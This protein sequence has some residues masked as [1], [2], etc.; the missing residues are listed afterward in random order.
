MADIDVRGEQV[1]VLGGGDTGADC[2]G[3]AHRQGAAS[4]LNLHY[5]PAP[6]DVRDPSSPWPFTPVLLRVS[7]SHEEGGDRGWSVLAQALVGEDRVRAL[8]C[9]DVTWD[10]G[11]QLVE[12]SERD[13]PADRVLVA[14]GYAGV[15]ASWLDELGVTCARGTIDTDGDGLAAQGVF[16]CGDATLGASLVVDAIQEG[17]AVAASI[18]R[19][20]RG[21]TRLRVLEDTAPLR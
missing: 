19:H 4:V 11:M 12:G 3:T 7:S 5:K 9:V 15:D 10:D 8:R 17:L 2:V 6:P 18:D 21:R 14:V 16:A 1:I 13:I 20:L